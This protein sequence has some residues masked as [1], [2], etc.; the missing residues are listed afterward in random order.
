MSVLWKKD[1]KRLRAEE[2]KEFGTIYTRVWAAPDLSLTTLGLNK[3]ADLPVIS[4]AEIVDVRI[5]PNPEAPGKMMVTVQAFLADLFSG[6][7]RTDTTRELAKT[8]TFN[9]RPGMVELVRN[10]EIDDSDLTEGALGWTATGLPVQGDDYPS[11]AW[12]ITPTV[13][14]VQIDPEYTT[15]RSRATVIYTAYLAWDD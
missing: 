13:L 9:K 1:I 5:G 7:S 3:G 14:E 11:G 10:F 2:Q 8:R 12:T 4:Y 15:S 6:V